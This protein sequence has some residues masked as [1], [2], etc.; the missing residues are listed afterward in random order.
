MGIP[1]ILLSLLVALTD[2][3]PVLDFSTKFSLTVKAIFS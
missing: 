1:S 3:R 2:L